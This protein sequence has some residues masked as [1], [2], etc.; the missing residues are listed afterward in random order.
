MPW[1]TRN[2]EC[3]LLRTTPRTR[4]RIRCTPSPKK[5]TNSGRRLQHIHDVIETSNV[6]ALISGR[7]QTI[8]RR[9]MKLISIHGHTRVQNLTIQRQALL[10]SCTSHSSF[11]RVATLRSRHG[12]IPTWQRSRSS[13]RSVCVYGRQSQLPLPYSS[14]S[15][16][17]VPMPPSLWRRS[18]MLKVLSAV[19]GCV[20]Q[21]PTE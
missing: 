11:R 19:R 8:A 17:Q 2:I 12:M 15:G 4:K 16:V 1:I 9:S 21:R 7:H 3:R 13:S 5:S 18:I 6:P 14:S 20:S 10:P